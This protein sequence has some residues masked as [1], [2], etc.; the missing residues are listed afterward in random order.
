M[1]RGQIQIMYDHEIAA[2]RAN[3]QLCAIRRYATAHKT[4][5]MKYLLIDQTLFG[6]RVDVPGENAAIKARGDQQMIFVRVL[7]VLHPIGV[8]MQTAHFLLQIAQVPQGHSV[9]IGAGGKIAIIQKF[10]AIY[11]A[12][13]YINQLIRLLGGYGIEYQY[14]LLFTG[15]H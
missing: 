3:Y 2:R 12:L 10:N 11:I 14:G 9:V 5:C 13:V 6:V 1:Q 4:T 7:N 15:C 8:T